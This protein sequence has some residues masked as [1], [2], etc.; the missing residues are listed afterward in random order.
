MVVEDHPDSADAMGKMLTALGARAVIAYDGWQAL[1]VL[2][3]QVP[4]AV[5]CDLRMPGMDGFDLIARVRRDPHLKGA[6]VVAVTA[7]ATDADYR[8]SLEAGF[9]AHVAKPIDFAALAGVMARLGI[10]ARAGRRRAITKHR[11]RRRDRGHS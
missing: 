5:L 3:D 11:L 1:E 8:R 4:D 6:P 2:R 7:L 9:D 10:R